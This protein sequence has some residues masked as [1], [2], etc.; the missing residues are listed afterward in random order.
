MPIERGREL[1]ERGLLDHAGLGREEHETVVAVFADCQHGVDLLAFVELGQQVHDRAA[2]RIRTGHRELERAQPEHAP[3][4]GEAEDGVVAVGDEDAFD[5]IELLDRGGRT[6][7]P[8]ATLRAVVGHRLGLRITRMR[9]RHD[10]VLLVDQVL[11]LQVF[12]VV[13]DDGATLVAELF[14]HFEQF[15]ADQAQQQRGVGQDRDQSADRLEQFLVLVGQLFLL[16]PG[17]LLQAHVED[18]LDLHFRQLIAVLEQ[19]FVGGQVFRSRQRRAG[20]AEQGAHQAGLPTPR[21]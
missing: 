7:P 3:A 18:F 4:R 8:A 15:G 9:Q 17:Q 14:L 5:E 11:V 19:A 6:P 13:L 2:A 12:L 21:Q 20:L 10:Q 16:Q 1:A